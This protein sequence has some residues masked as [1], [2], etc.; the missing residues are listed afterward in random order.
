MKLQFQTLLLILA[1]EVVDCNEIR[2]FLQGFDK[3][4]INSDGKETKV[5]HNYFQN[6]TWKPFASKS[7]NTI[8]RKVVY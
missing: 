8:L 6:L 7:Q 1:V 4:V 5:L 2:V 3:G